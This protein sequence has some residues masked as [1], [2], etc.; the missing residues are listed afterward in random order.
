MNLKFFPPKQKT[1]CPQNSFTLKGS[2]SNTE[3]TEM[4]TTRII[5]QS[6]FYES[7]PGVALDSPNSK[8]KIPKFYHQSFTIPNILR[9]PHI[10]THISSPNKHIPQPQKKS[11]IQ[12]KTGK[13]K[14]TAN[15]RGPCWSNLWPKNV[16]PGWKEKV[17]KTHQRLQ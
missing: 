17:R 14:K 4:C 1:L 12:T 11:K 13:K 10:V 9:P 2:R 15:S 8:K 3:N 7:L 5:Y 16:N 6:K